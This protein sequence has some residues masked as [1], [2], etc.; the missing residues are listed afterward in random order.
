[1]LLGAYAWTDRPALVFA[2]GSRQGPN[3]RAEAISLPLS[4]DND[5]EHTTYR[6]RLHYTAGRTF[7]SRLRIVPD[8][9]VR[10]LTVNGERVPLDSIGS[11]KLCD[12]R[13]G[14]DIDVGRL[15][16]RGD[17]E[18][19]L[20]VENLSGPGGLAVYSIRGEGGVS[21]SSVVMLLAL[22]LACFGAVYRMRLPTW[23][24]WVTAALLALAGWIR[25]RFVFDWHPPECFVFSDMGGYVD[26]AHELVRGHVS[27]SLGFQPIGY[28]LV[29]A[30]SLRLVGDFTLAD[31]AHV[32][33]GWA[34]VV[35]VWRASS[36]W[37]RERAGLFVLGITA[38]HFPFISLS[39]FFVAET[40]F[41]FQLALLFY[42]LAR[43]A[44][45][46]K[47]IAALAIGALYM[48]AL[49]IKGNNTFFGPLVI[50]WMAFW[51]LRHKRAEWL[52]L[53]RR[54]VVPVAAFCVGAALVVA[55]H[56][57]Y[58][59]KSF[60]HAQ[61]SAPTAALNLVEGKCPSKNNH[62]SLGYGWLSPLF[63]Q[64]GETEEKHWPRPFTDT[65]YFW[66]A[67]IDCI[68]QDPWV[69]ATSLRYV[70]YLFFD[71]LLWP[72]ISGDLGGLVR[73]SGMLFAA[74]LFPNIL[75]G[76][77]IIA[78]RPRSRW[79]LFATLGMSIMLCSWFFKS[80]LRYRVPFDVVFIPIAVL[81]GSWA[82]VRLRK[83]GRG[84]RRVLEGA[85][86]PRGAGGAEVEA[87]GE[88]GHEAGAPVEPQASA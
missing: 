24:K 58:T 2:S 37:L 78:R 27:E 46:W 4:R 80:E 68:R 85:R 21:V 87:T 12:F 32:V 18:L 31:W 29:L 43:F 13:G 30:Q 15:L 81:G 44:F 86:D 55:S 3:A 73:P 63:V 17:N 74:F 59:Y 7:R 47:P 8:D 64:L 52:R 51:I 9:C 71:N 35:L 14:F 56:A 60:G 70:Y 23:Q 25:Y 5:P 82:S 77:I 61:V 54:L 57:A 48:S 20:Q 79:G 66:G 84:P 42:C 19:D 1:V 67:G 88:E 75:L 72:S 36:R 22:V 62:D 65:R 49:W 11:T 39:G 34:T 16:H 33:C 10:S 26:R 83:V 40:F 41:T 38:L 76:W 69:L 6:Y 50:A 53:T 28:S 45:P